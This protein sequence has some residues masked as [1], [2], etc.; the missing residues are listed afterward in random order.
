MRFK[1]EGCGKETR[2]GNG[3]INL[4]CQSC[5]CYDLIFDSYVH[6]VPMISSDKVK[7]VQVKPGDS[8]FG[9]YGPGSIWLVTGEGAPL[10]SEIPPCL[11]QLIEAPE[12]PPVE[13][14][15]DDPAK[16]PKDIEEKKHKPKIVHTTKRLRVKLG[17]I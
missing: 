13:T 11:S 12:N 4:V 16:D 3:R 15:S 8:F 6:A 10:Q 5:G 1:C 17:N 2:F 9:N 14:H 7:E